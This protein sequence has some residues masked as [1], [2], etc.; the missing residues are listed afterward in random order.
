MPYRNLDVLDAAEK[1]AE[2][3]NKLI[4]RKRRRRLLHVPQL[5]DAAQSVRANIAEAFGRGDGPDRRRVLRIARAEADE[6]IQHLKTNF[7]DERLEPTEYWPVRNR[8]IVIVKMLKSLGS[9]GRGER[10][11]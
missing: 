2:M 4:A 1:A 11:T 9:R 7:A 3:V 10:D 8:Y 6:V 5:R